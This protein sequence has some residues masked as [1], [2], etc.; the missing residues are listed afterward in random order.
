MIMSIVVSGLYLSWLLID[1][2]WSR[3]GL[4]LANVVLL[5][6]AI[7]MVIGGDPIMII[8]IFLALYFGFETYKYMVAHENDK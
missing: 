1:T 6:S 3:K 8:D 5:I 7:L 2:D 4:V